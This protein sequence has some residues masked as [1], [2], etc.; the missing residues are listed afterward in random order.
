MTFKQYLRTREMEQSPAGD[1]ARDVLADRGSP[2]TFEDLWRHVE[3]QGAPGV[4]L[5]ALDEL[6]DGFVRQRT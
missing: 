6:N 1:V 2:D 4:V 5:E 3:S